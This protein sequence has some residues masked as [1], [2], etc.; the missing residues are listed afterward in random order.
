MR[1]LMLGKSFT[2]DHD[3]SRMISMM[4]GL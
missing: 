3:I 4:A 2:Y 1:I